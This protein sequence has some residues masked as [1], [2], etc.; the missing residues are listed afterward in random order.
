MTR[1]LITILAAGLVAAGLAAD[2]PK[3]D[4]RK[5]AA[6]KADVAK[7]RGEWDVV[8]LIQD[9]EEKMAADE[10]AKLRL[11]VDGDKRVLKAVDEVRS[12]AT[13]TI[14]PTVSPKQITITVSAGPLKGQALVGIYEV[15]DDT[16][17]ICL[18]LAGT[19]RP[20]ELAS[21]PGGGT[22]LQKFRRVKR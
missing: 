12:E 13:F 17:T 15:D 6:I 4:A 3:P 19:D 16:H 10:R 21:K 5:A 20:N 8:E 7:F 11:A 18:A 2:D 9:G 1:A 14:D 22:L